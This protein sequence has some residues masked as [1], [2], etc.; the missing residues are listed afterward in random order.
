MLKNFVLVNSLAAFNFAK[1]KIK[2]PNIVWL[3]TS[4]YLDNYFKFNGIKYFNIEKYFSREEYNKISIALVSI[5][6]ISV[7]KLIV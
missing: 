1:K 4:P 7:K 5:C 3:T 6:K 2:N